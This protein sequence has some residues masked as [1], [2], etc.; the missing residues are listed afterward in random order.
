VSVPADRP[1]T[2]GA[3]VAAASGCRAADGARWEVLTDHQEWSHPPLPLP[4][5]PWAWYQ[6]A[7]LGG[8]QAVIAD[9]AYPV[10]DE[11]VGSRHAGREA[12]TARWCGLPGAVPVLCAAA[13]AGGVQALQGAV[14]AALAEDLPLRRMVVA[15]VC[16][17]SGALPAAVQAAVTMLEPRVAA[18]LEVP[19]DPQLRAHGLHDP[20]RLRARTQRAAGELAQAVLEVARTVWGDPLPVAPVPAPLPGSS[21]LP[22]PS[23]KREEVT[24]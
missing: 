24:V 20:A 12:V 8:W 15:L 5:D 4:V 1:L 17:A 18:V 22:A 14:M 21:V 11:L 10:A 19:H 7:A 9:T 6:L 2:V 16:T 13:N 3:V 23:H